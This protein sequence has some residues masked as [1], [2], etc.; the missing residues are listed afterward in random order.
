P[1]VVLSPAAHRHTER[2]VE[3]GHLVRSR[4]V[5][6]SLVLDRQ[7]R[8]PVQGGVHIPADSHDPGGHR[9]E[10][11]A[12]GP[13]HSRAVTSGQSSRLTAPLTRPRDA[14]SPRSTKTLQPPT[15]SAPPR[16]LPK[17]CGARATPPVHPVGRRLAPSPA[18]FSA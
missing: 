15:R 8:S 16:S 5:S 4:Q 2:A 11:P 7:P 1:T 10:G 13:H 9:R 12:A 6:G 17:R 18:P 3:A 14:E